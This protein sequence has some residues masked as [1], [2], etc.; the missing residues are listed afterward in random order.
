[1]RHKTPL[2]W[3]VCFT[4]VAVLS[5]CASAQPTATAL[6]TAPATSVPPTATALPTP[7]PATTDFPTGVFVFGGSRRWELRADGTDLWTGYASDEGTY[8]VIGDQIVFKG[9]WCGDDEGLYTWTY[10][11]TVLQ[12]KVLRDRCARRRA[13][14][15]LTKWKRAP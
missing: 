14:M 5:A 15:N 3:I 6:P 4:S 8:T 9:G 11:G 13:E 2:T 10:D 12:C 1:M 7:G